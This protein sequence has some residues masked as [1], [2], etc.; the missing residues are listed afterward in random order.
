MATQRV[1]PCQTRHSPP[2]RALLHV[3]LYV[4][5][6]RGKVRELLALT[7]VLLYFTQNWRLR[8]I[9]DENI[10]IPSCVIYGL[11]LNS[12]WYRIASVI[13]RSCSIVHC[14]TRQNS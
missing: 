2:N 9:P 11:N 4:R 6:K 10:E 8:R 3:V 14:V 12:P 7:N 1:A 5:A 13:E